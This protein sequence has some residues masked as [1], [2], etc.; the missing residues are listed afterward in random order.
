MERL[1]EPTVQIVI[2]QA[3]INTV[4]NKKMKWTFAEDTGIHSSQDPESNPITQTPEAEAKH[5]LIWWSCKQKQYVR[6]TMKGEY[7]ITEESAYFCSGKR[8]TD[9]LRH[10]PIVYFCTLQDE[11]VQKQIHYLPTFFTP[12]DVQT[13]TYKPLKDT[14]PSVSSEGDFK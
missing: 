7:K 11:T 10:A 3:G 4:Q 13:F 9:F 8:T 5:S 2:E 12:S 1:N 14:L 6:Y